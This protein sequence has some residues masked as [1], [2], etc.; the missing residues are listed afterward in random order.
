[1]EVTSC[2][3][4]LVLCPL[5]QGEAGRGSSAERSRTK[6]ERGNNG[7]LSSGLLFLFPSLF[8][9]LYLLSLCPYSLSVSLCLH[10]HLFPLKDLK[11]LSL[12][13]TGT[14]QFKV[15]CRH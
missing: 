10:F 15:F 13:L 4:L 6:Q 5:I 2:S 3:L 8:L 11:G 1:M 12:N 7:T 14:S 9:S